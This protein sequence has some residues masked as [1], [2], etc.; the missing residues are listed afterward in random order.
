MDKHLGEDESGYKFNWLD[1]Y[2]MLI[3]IV[4]AII[5]VLWLALYNPHY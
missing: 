3:V 2:W 4:G 1:D 5:A